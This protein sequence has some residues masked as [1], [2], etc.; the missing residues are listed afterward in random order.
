MNKQTVRDIDL[1]GKRV[2]VRVD[3]NVPVKNDVV[4]DA[5]RIE[6]GLET[7]KYL[8]DQG[9]SLVLLSHLG[10]PKGEPDSQYSL[11]P[12]AAKASELLGRDITFYDDCV[13]DDMMAAA[14]DLQPG[15]VIMGENVRFHAEELA[16]DEAFIAKL[17]ELGEVYVNDAFAVD[18]RDQAS[19]SG[20]A[21]HLPAVAGLLVE[22]EVNYI[23]GAL[24]KPNRPLVAVLGGA[25][26]STKVALLEHLIPKV[27]ALFLTGPVANTFMLA[28]GQN[29]GKSIAEPTMIETVKHLLDIAKAENTELFLPEEV[30]VSKSIE[31]PKK[32]R[33]VRA[34]QVEDDDYILDA[35]PA[36]A[37][38]L[39]TAVY[40]FLDFDNKSTVV[41]NGPLGL[42]EIP[43]FT[44]GSRAMAKAILDL[45]GISIVGG[46]DTAG[47]VDAEGLHDK[48]TWVSTGGGASLELMSG[49]PMPG[50]DSLLDKA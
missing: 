12:V 29:I 36:Y 38:Q 33:T 8:L 3:Y 31:E 39:A 14:K 32:V 23:Q 37:K 6:A 15:Q 9:C 43:E 48:F 42:T 1:K 20:V 34:S 44:E 26:V 21:K 7:L 27:D 11:K 4:Q 5:F 22:K 35:T 10:E 45:K 41:W 19:V 30:V 17:A 25:K 13:G 40:D 18:H 50:I 46:G 2:L 16:N 28:K 24:E 47:F 49:K